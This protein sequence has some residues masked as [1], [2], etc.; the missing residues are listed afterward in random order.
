M[1]R[2]WSPL[3]ER[4]FT[5]VETPQA[6]ADADGVFKKNAVVRAVAGSGK[7]TTIVE[8]N[9]RA[10]RMGSTVFLAF[11]KAIADELKAR[12]VNAKTF[13]SL[14]MGSVMQARGV[15]E[16]DFKK[17][18]RVF[19]AVAYPKGMGMYQKLVLRLVGLA[20]QS[21]IG[22]LI[23]DTPDAWINIINHHGLDIDDG[24]TLHDAIDLAS[25]VLEAHVADVQVNFDD[26]L[27]MPVRLG[28]TLPKFDFVFV[29][30]AQDTNAIQRE[31]LRKVLPPHG[32]LIAVGDPQQAIYGFRGSDNASL[33]TVAEEFDCVEL[34][35]NVSYRCP[36]SVVKYAQQWVPDIQ[37]RDGAPEGLVKDLGKEWGLTTF[38]PGDL[39]VCRTTRHLVA[40]GF[41]L[42]R[43]QIPAH[44]MGKELG[45]GLKTLIN[46]MGTRDLDILSQKVMVWRD[47]EAEKALKMDE[48][49]KAEAIYDKAECIVG[50]I[51]GMPEDMRSFEQVEAVIDYLFAP[52][53]NAIT[54]A[55][56]HKAKGL[57]AERVYWLARDQCPPRWARQDW[58]KEQ[59]QN[60]MYVAVTRAKSELYF[61][62][63]IR[64][65]GARDDLNGLEALMERHQGRNVKSLKEAQAVVAQV[66]GGSAKRPSGAMRPTLPGINLDV[67][68]GD[69]NDQI[70][71]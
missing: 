20:K 29:D 25:E 27:Y 15:K 37:A 42:I 46:K 11:N 58:E 13:H 41:K 52:T 69:F 39:V 55:T 35:L 50:I 48:P 36:T 43:A 40:L 68:E 47:R 60:L 3:Q 64:S 8:A 31:L 57:E 4:V 21:G 19:R 10:R 28:L 9:N 62:E 14:C 5:F 59:E 66:V 22:C 49:N 32:R 18:I 24:C 65:G 53:A 51:D 34:P 70:P 6:L 1:Q 12:G 26:M 38:K 7:T 45:D 67:P 71:F 61:L 17:D 23:K 63:E 56:I 30:E 16:I 33:Q 44:I 54:L 2:V